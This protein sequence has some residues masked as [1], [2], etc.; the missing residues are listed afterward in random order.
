MRPPCLSRSRPM[1]TTS[2]GAS[3]AGTPPG[4]SCSSKT[5]LTGELKHE[6]VQFVFARFSPDGRTMAIIAARAVR[7]RLPL[8]E[9]DAF[10]T[11]DVAFSPDGRFLATRSQAGA[12][13]KAHDPPDAVFGR[14]HALP[15]SNGDAI[16]VS[17]LAAL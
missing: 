15:A 4:M 9:P 12:A 3:A 8:P 16:D 6:G 10:S 11:H 14:P 17:P 5:L 7:A 1:R 2:C 13:I